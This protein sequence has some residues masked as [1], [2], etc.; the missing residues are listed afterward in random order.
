MKKTKV[1]R[2]MTGKDFVSVFFLAL[3]LL[4]A[5]ALFAS[6]DGS[7]SSR[8]PSRGELVITEVT[9]P[10]ITEEPTDYEDPYRYDNNVSIWELF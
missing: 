6:N 2:K 8:D 10:P 1:K 9:D 7:G 4:G 5:I 3:F